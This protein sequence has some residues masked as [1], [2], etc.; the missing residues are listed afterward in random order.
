MIYFDNAAT[1]YPKPEVV[2]K[3]LDEANR[4]L[5]FNAG[6]GNY[7]EA[8]NAF[9]LIESTRMFLCEKA[10][11]KY[12]TFT[13]SATH[14]LN[15][16]IAGINFEKEDI[17]YCSPYDHN[18]VVRTLNAYAIKIGF[19]L[20]TIP[21]NKD[22]SIDLEKFEFDCIIEK[23]KAIFCSHV[24]NVTGYVHPIDEIGSISAKVQSIFVVDGA[25]AFGLIPVNI[26]NMNIDYYVFAGHKTLYGPFGIAGYFYNSS[27]LKLS[28]FGGTGSDSLN[29][30]MPEKGSSRFE[31]SSPNIVA[32]A[33]LFESSK[34]A[35]DTNV[36]DHETYLV[37]YAIDK[38]KNIDG[39]IIYNNSN[40]PNV[41]IISLNLEGYNS[42]D[43]AE[44]LSKDYGICTRGGYHCCPF[45][46]DILNTKQ[47]LG[48]VRVSF[49]YFNDTEEIDKLVEALEDISLN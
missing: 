4:T 37:N 8:N 15:Q 39:I 13:P 9:K 46:H 12:L 47:Y 45:I 38:L 29:L 30:N 41:G 16:I 11:A 2:Y 20:K 31:P 7:N 18:A 43:L 33:G 23:P 1:T 6:R 35:F 17:V 14:S 48:T 40:M 5:A 27:N 3:T 42:E 26:T 10:N 44:I 49:N 25:Q 32:I 36:Y 28:V 19:K 24:S 21:L 34:W 22:C